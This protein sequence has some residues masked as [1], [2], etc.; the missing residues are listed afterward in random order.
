MRIKERLQNSSTYHLANDRITSQKPAWY[1][2]NEQH[3]QSRRAEETFGG[4][5]IKFTKSDQ[6]YPGS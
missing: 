4:L 3:N 2:R 1:R 6:P 5:H